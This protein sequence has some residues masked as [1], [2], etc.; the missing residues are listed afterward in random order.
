MA[1]RIG[2][3][4]KIGADLGGFSP[5]LKIIRS[6]PCGSAGKESTCKA[7]DLGSIPGLGRSPGEGKGYPLQ[8][9]GLENSM[10]CI[11]HEVSKSRTRLNDFFY[12]LFKIIG[13]SLPKI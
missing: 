2:A 8:Y 7:G 10:D 5:T 13:G 1:K 3:V 12:F 11:V 9:S 4:G 6:F